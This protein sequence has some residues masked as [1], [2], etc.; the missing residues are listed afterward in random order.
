LVIEQAKRV[1]KIEAEAI[2]A[3]TE[4]INE[5]FVKAVDLIFFCKGKIVVTGVGKSGLIGQKIASTL[6]STGTPS[7]FMHPAEGIHGDLGMLSKNDVVIAIS[8]SGESNEISQIIP[9]VKRMGLPLISMT[10]NRISTLAKSGDVVLDISV[11]EEACPLGLAPTAST[12]ATLAM[13]DALAV[14]VLDKRGFKKEDF[15]LLHP[16]GSLGKSLLVRVS[17]LMHTGEAIPLVTENTVMKVALF[18]ITSKRFGVTGVVDD[19]GFLEGAI[20]DGD[21][22]RAMEKGLDVLNKKASEIMTRNPKK[23]GADALAAEALQKM[24]LHSITSLFVMDGEK[25]AGIVHLHD[26]LKVGVV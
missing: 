24:E 19:E 6:A 13:G 11:K 26:L 10:G 5:S 17:D 1:L 21:L 25:V 2:S 8:N 20:T 18:E 7:F 15:A 22:R 23:I 4:R 14:A 3:L 12:T 16:G 9:V